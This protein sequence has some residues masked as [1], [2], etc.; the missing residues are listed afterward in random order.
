VQP[1]DRGG[2]PDGFDPGTR[3]PAGVF[4]NDH[5]IPAEQEE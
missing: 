4:F 5:R 1:A 3:M 2:L